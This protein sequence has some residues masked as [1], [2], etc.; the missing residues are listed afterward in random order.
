MKSQLNPRT[1]VLKLQHKS[2]IIRLVEKTFVTANNCYS[3]ICNDNIN[4]TPTHN[5]TAYFYEYLIKTNHKA[6]FYK[7]IIS[8]CLSLEW[9]VACVCKLELSTAMRTTLWLSGLWKLLLGTLKTGQ[10]DLAEHGI[11]SVYNWTHMP[12]VWIYQLQLHLQVNTTDNWHII[13]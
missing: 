2:V 3:L 13:C 11:T 12:T 8:C 6:G 10:R 1:A 4:N 7:C 5:Q 9:R